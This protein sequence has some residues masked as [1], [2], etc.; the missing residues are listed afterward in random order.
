ARL[1]GAY[2]EEDEFH[3][4]RALSRAD[5]DPQAIRAYRRFARAHP[6]HARAP[7]ATYLAAWL[8]MR[9]GARAGERQM[10]RFLR[11]PLAA[12]ALGLARDATWQLALAAFERGQHR[13]AEARFE[14]YAA[15]G[16]DP[17][18]RARGTYW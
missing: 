9:H 1:S 5:R 18:I 6:A 16:T 7:E 8:E 14:R 2:A 10:D 15:M 17:L 4:A 3:A 11:S 12:R 13:S